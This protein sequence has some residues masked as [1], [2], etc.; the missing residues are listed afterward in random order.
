MCLSGACC[1]LTSLDDVVEGDW[2]LL[3]VGHGD[4]RRFV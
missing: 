3:S 1:W 2:L 4:L